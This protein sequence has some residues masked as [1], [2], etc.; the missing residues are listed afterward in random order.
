MR[1]LWRLAGETPEESPTDTAPRLYVET[2]N[3]IRLA[4]SHGGWAAAA[5]SFSR[6][7][8]GPAVVCVDT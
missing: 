2:L 6:Q 8:H 3:E 7:I 1:G 4:A 5:P